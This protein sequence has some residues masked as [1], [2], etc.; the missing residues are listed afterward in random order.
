[1]PIEV[2]D[3]ATELA[4]AERAFERPP[5]RTETGLDVADPALVQLRKACR[6][7]DGGRQ[8]FD[9]GYYTLAIEASFTALEKSLLYWLVVE[10]HR[11]GSRP[12]QSHTTAINQSVDVGLCS[13]VVVTDSS[14]CGTETGPGRTIATASRPR[15][16]R[17]R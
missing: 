10:G 17:R 2:G 4:A 6:T 15:A 7:L 8:L 9:A 12:P 1:M 3:V 5:E 13:D 16:A 14:N 11:D